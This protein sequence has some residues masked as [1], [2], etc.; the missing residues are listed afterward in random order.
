MNPSKKEKEKKKPCTETVREGCVCKWS[1][2]RP[3]RRVECRHRGKI[4]RKRETET[5]TE[6]EKERK[7]EQLAGLPRAP[8]SFLASRRV[9][10]LPRGR[11][12]VIPM[13]D[14][15]HSGDAMSPDTRRELVGSGLMVLVQRVEGTVRGV[16]GSWHTL[17]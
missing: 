6:K 12:M 17:G 9:C 13:E 15:L 3:P 5:E 2:S 16:K 14:W 4:E 10:K 8:A 1:V 11:P 7:R